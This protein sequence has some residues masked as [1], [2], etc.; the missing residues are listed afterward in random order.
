[1]VVVKGYGIIRVELIHWRTL[2]VE[3]DKIDYIDEVTF[4]NDTVP[5]IG[6]KA[7]ELS[8]K[9]DIVFYE[10]IFLNLIF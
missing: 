6:T 7:Y 1:M 9:S 2:S 10:V 8:Y 3:K 4:P 5:K